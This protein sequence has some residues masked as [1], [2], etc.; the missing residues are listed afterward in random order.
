MITRHFRTFPALSFLTLGLGLFQ[1]ACSGDSPKDPSLAPGGSGGDISAPGSGGDA[2]ATGGALGTGG[3]ATG[4]GGDATGAGGSPSGD[5]ATFKV[6]GAK[7][8]DR[9]GE[10]VVLRGV[11]EMIV[12]SAGRDG[13]PEYSEIA[14]TGAN[15]VRIVWNKE[16]TAQQLD[17]AIAGALAEQLIPMIENHDATGDL[18]LL[19]E[20]VDYWTQPE[21]VA[22]LKKYE[23]DLL[24]NIANEA[25]DG[26][27]TSATYQ[28]A[29]ETAITRLRETGLVLPLILDAPQWGQNI[30]VIQ[31]TWQA[32]S[33][34]DPE[35]NLLYSVHTWWHDPMGV[36]VKAELAESSEAGMPLIVGEFSHHAV[37]QC[38]QAPF[39]YSVLLDESQRLGIGWL[40]WSWG[41]VPNGDCQ[42][43][44]GFDMTVDGVFGEWSAA[45]AEEIAISHSASMKN[46]SVRPSS[47]VTGACP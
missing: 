36:R 19:P 35:H 34:H 7:L 1:G 31:A 32:L 23:Q 13:T 46:T 28:S 5:V 43:E 18:T 8:K 45:W 40:V 26:A 30:D 16:G 14:K 39:A 20:V 41:A 4:T 29:Y 33:A 17:V 27:V 42:G 37:Y 9:C 2:P 44:G 38:D 12:W 6:D 21:V 3:D 25:G 47:I 22:V 10:E 11:N 15:V 24:L